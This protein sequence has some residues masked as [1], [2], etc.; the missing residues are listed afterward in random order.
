MQEI[1]IL[2]LG[3]GKVGT[4][5][6]QQL[7]K[8]KST[9]EHLYKVKINIIGLYKSSGGISSLQGIPNLHKIVRLKTPERWLNRLLSGGGI[10]K[11]SVKRL[12][13]ASKLPLI[14]ID[15]TSS[16]QTGKLLEQALKK[17]AYAV[18]S[19]K[20]PL[21]SEY[22]NFKILQ[23]YH[24]RLFFETT[25]GAGLPIISTI[26]ELL[27]TGDKIIEIQGCF[28]GTLGY[29]FSQLETGSAFSDIVKKAKDLGFTEPDPRDDLSGTDV[30]RKA[31]IL[32]RIIGQKINLKDFGIQ[33][34][35]PDKLKNITVDDFLNNINTLDDGFRGMMEKAR[36]KNCTLRYVASVSAGKIS[37][38]LKQIPKNSDIGTLN[39]PDNIA[40]IKTNRYNKNPL[41][42]KGPGAGKEVTAAGVFGDLLKIIKI[43]KGNTL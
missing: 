18:L 35:Y 21:S 24:H 25:V 28:S 20:K 19:N 3:P 37:V 27:E 17:G 10:G 4:A 13:A 40:V 31:L 43:I 1:N 9:L 12:I 6:L 2:H 8:N 41:I 32:A 36:N 16:D 30:A 7:L 29:I 5:F 38:G 26:K 23:K 33:S 39:G 15:T 42:I 14:V 22:Q 11:L 34:L